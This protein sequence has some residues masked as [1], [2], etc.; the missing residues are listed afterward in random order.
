[1]ITSGGRRR[2]GV[3]GRYG[4][5]GFGRVTF[6]KDATCKTKAL[7]GWVILK[8]DLLVTRIHILSHAWAAHTSVRRVS[9]WGTRG[10]HIP[11]CTE[12]VTGTRGLHI[13]PCT[14][15]VTE[16]HPGCQN[17]LACQGN[18]IKSRVICGNTTR[19][20]FCVRSVR[21][22]FPPLVVFTDTAIGYGQAAGFRIRRHES[23][24]P[25]KWGGIA[26]P[27]K[28]VLA[29]L[30]RF[31]F[32]GVRQPGSVICSTEKGDRY[33]WARSHVL[34]KRL[35]ARFCPSVRPSECISAAPTGGTSVRFDTGD[36]TK[37]CWENSNLL[38]TGLKYMA[39][40]W[41]LK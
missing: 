13:P 41:W 35:L 23:T 9:N 22:A 40:T 6:G 28:Q 12:W 3:W 19:H 14:E 11:P 18:H 31:L 20:S 36:F 32:H 17:C 33:F 38:K 15:W 37:I 8:C 21:Q 26:D 34:E 30:E 4:G 29:Y 1:M 2:Y 24:E 25:M 7:V 5:E 16:A 39:V 27:T 10:L